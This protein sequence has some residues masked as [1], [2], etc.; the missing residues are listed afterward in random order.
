MLYLFFFPTKEIKYL[1]L[2]MLQFRQI[3]KSNKGPADQ[4]LKIGVV[5][6]ILKMKQ[7]LK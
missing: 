3:Q 6:L 2:I 1:V 7:F 5:I 4:L